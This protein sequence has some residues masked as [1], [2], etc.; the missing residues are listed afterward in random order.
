M[1]N[2]MNKLE[3]KLGKF[4]IPNLTIYILILYAIGYVL[5]LSSATGLILYDKFSLDVYQI[6]HGLQIWRLFTW[7]IIPPRTLGI[8]IVI[9]FMFYYF[10]GTSLERTIGT[11]RYNVFIFG[12]FILM[13]VGAFVTY[14]IYSRAFTNPEDLA[15][16]SYYGGYMLSTYY[17]QQVVFLLFAIFYPNVVVYFMMLIPIKVKYLGIAY[18]GL[19]LLSMLEA[20][21]TAVR[22]PTF[23]SFFTVAAIL[24]QLLNLLLFYMSIGRMNHLKPKEIKRRQTFK[25]NAQIRPRG[26]TRHKCAVCGRTEEDNPD[27]EF[28]FCSKCNGNYEY[29]QDHLFTHQH[30]Q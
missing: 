30:V 25:Q 16:V 28:R 14:F 29:C 11:F 13:I 21:S 26:G 20:F 17:I 15:A 24:S 3:R 19:L 12:G 7:V 27:L 10:L 1:N 9:T 8:F 23:G 18:S 2:F 6:I 4:A 5:Q 22:Y